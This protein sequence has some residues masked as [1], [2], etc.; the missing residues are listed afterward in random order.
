M[1]RIGLAPISLPSG[2]SLR[3][4]TA[5]VEVKG[6]KGVLQVPVAEGIK[7]NDESGTVSLERRDDSRTQKA[8]HGLTRALLANAVH[9]VSDGFE[10]VLEIKGTGYKAEGG[11][12]SLTLSLGFS[13]Q[14][15][16]PLPDG[17]T[18]KVEERGTVI[19]LAG[20]DKQ[21]IGQVAANLRALRP[22][23][24][25]KGK[26]IRYRGERISLKPGKAAGK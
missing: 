2:V 1:S 12:S 11:G 6:P 13:H 23:D 14:V 5:E 10:R 15:D 17:I 26:G 25:Y 20:I 18:A 3:V 4:N 19:F 8:L 21:K 9:G 22:P 7:V 24:P 16:F